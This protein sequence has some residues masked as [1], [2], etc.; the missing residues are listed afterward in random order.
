VISQLR[1]VAIAFDGRSAQ[2]ERAQRGG[3]VALRATAD[4]SPP[5]SV[6]SSMGAAQRISDGD[7]ASLCLS[8]RQLPQHGGGNRRVLSDMICSA[9]IETGRRASAQVQPHTQ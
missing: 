2:V 9:T 7:D 6:F 1:A 5:S 4:T 8:L 3:I